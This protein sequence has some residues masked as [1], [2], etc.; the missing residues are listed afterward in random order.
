VTES[1][2]LPS[3]SVIAIGELVVDWI[4]TRKSAIWDEP[5]TFLRSAGGNAANVAHALSRLGTDARL[6]AKVGDD[7]HANYLFSGLAQAGIDT[8]FVTRSSAFAT[9]QC[10]VLTDESD[11]NLFFNWPKPN[12]CHQLT[13]DDLSDELFEG[14]VALHATG[15]S[16][17]VEPRSSAVIEAMS[18]ARKANL[19]VSFDG[20]FP[21]GEGEKAKSHALEAMALAHMIKVNLAELF[22][23]LGE[24]Y[25]RPEENLLAEEQALAE[26]HLLGE[27]RSSIDIAKLAEY[28]QI[29]RSRTGAQLV[30][31]TLGAKGSII[32]SKDSY[33]APPVRVDIIDGDG[34]GV[35]AGDAYVAYVLS[36][37]VKGFSSALSRARNSDLNWPQVLTSDYFDWAE[38]ARS[39]NA[40]GALAT[41][42]VSASK[43]L[44]TLL[45]IEQLLANN[46]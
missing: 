2:D 28:A 10:Y 14:A 16:L 38:I 41:R 21:T 23:W 13:V 34:A 4:A 1:F 15:I 40:A 44:P 29:L 42:T 26:G 3:G 25:S 39:A 31:L 33:F 11:E 6:V 9:A 46:H 43:G 27:D 20:G 18:R 5:D 22:Y 24:S 32:V 8:T 7:L 35:G 37:L 30:L 45:E 12:A 19:L 17:T 36:R